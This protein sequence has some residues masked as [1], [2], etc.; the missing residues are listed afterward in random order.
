MPSHKMSTMDYWAIP[1]RS[2]SIPARA[3][4]LAG[5]NAIS[6]T[7]CWKRMQASVKTM[8]S[9]RYYKDTSI[10]IS[11]RVL[12]GTL[13]LEISMEKGCGELLAGCSARFET[14]RMFAVTAARGSIPRKR[15]SSCRFSSFADMLHAD[16][17]SGCRPTYTFP[18]RSQRGQDR[19]KFNLTYPP[20]YPVMTRLQGFLMMSA[21]EITLRPDAGFGSHARVRRR[22][23]TIQQYWR[24]TNHVL[25]GHGDTIG[26]R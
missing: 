20:T 14:R 8:K 22:K 3:S 18:T 24:R 10:R 6:C 16:V 15:S 25:V 26:K 23:Q 9:R 19:Y 7:T 17:K 5:R 21:S 11:S 13:L 4:N 2:E 12:F 1:K